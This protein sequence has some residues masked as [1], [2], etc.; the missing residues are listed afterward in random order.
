MFS[1]ITLLKQKHDLHLN[2]ITLTE[3]WSM[4]PSRHN[5][6]HSPEW[7]S[8]ANA[9]RVRLRFQKNQNTKK[10][11]D[12]IVFGSSRIICIIIEIWFICLDHVIIE[13]V[14][15][16]AHHLCRDRNTIRLS[17]SCHRSESWLMWPSRHNHV[18][19]NH[20]TQTETWSMWQPRHIRPRLVSDAPSLYEECGAKRMKTT[21]RSITL[22]KPK[23][24]WSRWNP[25]R[26]TLFFVSI[27]SYSIWTQNHILRHNHMCLGPRTKKRTL[28]RTDLRLLD[29]TTGSAD[30]PS[31]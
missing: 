29:H 26:T 2:H 6:V 15:L 30:T 1:S 25:Y 20:T 28:A 4:W 7:R 31:F 14:E 18:Q 5:H 24:D 10:F 23:H 17:S 21:F 27:G 13:V 12:R 22:L 11:W 8:E 19:L 3:S 9:K 16:G